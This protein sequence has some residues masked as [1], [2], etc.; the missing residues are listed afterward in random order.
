MVDGCVNYQFAFTFTHM[1]LPVGQQF[2]VKI[3]LAK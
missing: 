1:L 2:N 3:R